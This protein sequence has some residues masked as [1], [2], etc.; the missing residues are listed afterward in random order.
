VVNT[1]ARLSSEAAA[2]EVLV[3]DEAMEMSG[4]PKDAHEKRELTLKG[5]QEMVEAWVVKGS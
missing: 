3:G 2:G 4:H 1:T 5:K